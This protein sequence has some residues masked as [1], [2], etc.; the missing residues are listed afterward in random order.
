MQQNTKT[1]NFTPIRGS[2]KTTQNENKNRRKYP[3]WSTNKVS[4]RRRKGT[5][6]ISW[7]CGL[8]LLSN[9]MMARIKDQ[10]LITYFFF[11]ITDCSSS[12]FTTEW[13][14]LGSQM[15]MVSHHPRQKEQTSVPPNTPID[16][17]RHSRPKVS[18]FWPKYA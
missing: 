17:S 5:V 14:L 9:M 15:P 12:F 18:Y 11:P 13:L 6:V 3:K 16:H 1:A 4:S 8:W 7:S 10:N 2:D